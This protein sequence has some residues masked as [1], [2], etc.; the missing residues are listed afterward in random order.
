[1]RQTIIFLFLL[2]AS[3]VYGQD[4]P[5]TKFP[6]W[7]EYIAGPDYPAKLTRKGIV[8]LVLELPDT[9][10]YEINITLTKKVWVGPPQTV[11]ANAPA[12][13]QGVSIQ[14]DYIGSTDA[15]DYV[16]YSVDLTGRTK[17]ALEY[18]RQWDNPTQGSAEI[19]SGSPT[20]TL[21]G[22]ISTPNTGS[23]S[24]YQTVETTITPST[25]TTVFIVFKTTGTGNIK[26]FTFK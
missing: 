2:M 19:R 13:Q 26:T 1:M 24:T 22:T 12:S 6:N 16:S 17:V 5:T 15:G 10:T 21:L 18:S 14:T 11:Q 8:P 3:A 20:G 9:S 25:A 23:W 4:T 7:Q